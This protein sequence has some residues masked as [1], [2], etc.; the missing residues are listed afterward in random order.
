MPR[1]FADWCSILGFLWAIGASLTAWW[2]SHKRTNERQT[3]VTFLIGLKPGIQGT[4]K[5]AVVKQINDM[6]A[7]LEPPKKS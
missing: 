4:N 6:L 2:Q 7:R 3:M 5:E 1:T